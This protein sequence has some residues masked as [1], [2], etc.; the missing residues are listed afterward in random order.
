MSV[1][2]RVVLS[3][4]ALS[5]VGCQSAGTGGAN[6][7]NDQ[8]NRPR[9]N[10]SDAL[11]PISQAGV[12]STTPAEDTGWKPSW[13]F[14]SA[15]RTTSGSVQACG[16]ATNQTLV[17]ARREAIE[18]ARASAMQIADAGLDDRVI[19]AATNPNAQGGYTVWVVLEMGGP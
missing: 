19:Q 11:K 8:A 14:D 16:M 3:L 1:R 4:V 12:P 18:R 5:L 9:T 6:S 17:D 15:T 10:Q 2:S 13:W 7:A